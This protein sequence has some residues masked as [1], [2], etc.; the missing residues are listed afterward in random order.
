MNEKEQIQLLY[1][2]AVGKRKNTAV[3]VTSFNTNVKED[4]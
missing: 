1:N 2:L 3:A 4:L